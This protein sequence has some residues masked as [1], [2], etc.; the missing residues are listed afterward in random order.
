MDE[1]IAPALIEKLKEYLSKKLCP[2]CGGSY[3]ITSVDY[4]DYN[5]DEFLAEIKCES[6]NRPG[7]VG[8]KDGMEIIEITKFNV[9]QHYTPCWKC[10][11]SDLSSIECENEDSM[12]DDTYR[13]YCEKFKT[14][15]YA[16]TQKNCEYY[17]RDVERVLF[18]YDF[19]H[20]TIYD[21]DEEMEFDE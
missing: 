20:D 4:R 13:I 21:Q 9:V 8:F 15:V 12:D 6:C 16:L 14:I 2:S 3:I 1:E 10:G 19:R 7:W 11:N 17:E 18:D 5:L